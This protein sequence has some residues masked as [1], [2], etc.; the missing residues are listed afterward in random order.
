MDPMKTLLPLVPLLLLAG[1]GSGA[2]A[3]GTA[4]EPIALVRTATAALGSAADQITV[5]GAAEAAPSGERTVVV[6]AE[7]IVV[8]I[9]APT[10]T[11][12][13]AGQAI[14]TLKPSRATATELAKAS[15][16]AAAAAA[17]YARAKR[18]RAD[19]LMSD[20]DVETARAAAATAQATRYNLGMG[21]RGLVL[22]APVAGT[23]QGL[24][25]K[26]GDQIAAGTSVASIAKAGDLRARFGIDPAMAQRVHSGQALTV[27]LGR[28]RCAPQ[29]C[30]R[31]RR[32]T[33]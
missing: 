19:G 30:R 18:M 16:D 5:Y 9:D 1:C 7:A 2:S 15:S 25:A 4:D 32:S 8:H 21:A 28:G 29:A 26:P 24:T 22:R 14:V 12:V 20:A 11:A 33:G 17:A 27:E 13:H 10:G 31:R 6:P 3:D 23:V